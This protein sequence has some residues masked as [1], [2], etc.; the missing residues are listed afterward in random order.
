MHNQNPL[1]YAKSWI[2]LISF[3]AFLM[4]SSDHHITFW[5]FQ[6]PSW[7]FVHAQIIHGWCE[8]VAYWVRRMIRTRWEAMLL[9]ALNNQPF[10]FQMYYWIDGITCDSTSTCRYLGVKRFIDAPESSRGNIAWNFDVIPSNVSTNGTTSLASLLPQGKIHLP[11]MW[12]WR[13][14]VEFLHAQY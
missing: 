9:P 7:H 4:V 8:S 10:Q 1:D 14:I 5:L 2:T 11:T 3:I 13:S 12:K 6:N